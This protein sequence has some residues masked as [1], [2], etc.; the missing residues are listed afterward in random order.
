MAYFLI[1]SMYM[2]HLF[3]F[4]YTQILTDAH[5][6]RYTDSRSGRAHA[7]QAPRLPLYNLPL[8]YR[9]SGACFAV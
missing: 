9:T 7:F 2:I 3:F 4:K 5:I 1:R 8:G 6:S